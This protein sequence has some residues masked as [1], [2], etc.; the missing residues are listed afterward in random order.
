MATLSPK[1]EATLKAG[2]ALAF[3]GLSEV[4]SEELPQVIEDIKFQLD[5][6][7]PGQPASFQQ[8]LTDSNTA[9]Q[10]IAA[11]TGNEK[12]EKDAVWIGQ[13]VTGIAQGKNVV[14]AIFASLFK[15]HSTAA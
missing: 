6:F 8:W 15:K 9:L 13:I 12:L 1:V 4:T 7:H 11:D 10:A 14:A 2:L 5:N 3:D